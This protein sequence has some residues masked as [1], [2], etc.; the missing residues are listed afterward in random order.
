[1]ATVAAMVVTTRCENIERAPRLQR[2]RAH[3]ALAV[4]HADGASLGAAR[5]PRPVGAEGDAP[6]K[7][8]DERACTGAL[9]QTRECLR[10]RAFTGVRTRTRRR[11]GI[12]S[13]EHH[14]WQEKTGSRTQH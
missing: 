1:M 13:Y 12:R 5:N 2:M 11:P 3:V 10:T 8:K 6:A 4:E 14:S 9:P 7:L